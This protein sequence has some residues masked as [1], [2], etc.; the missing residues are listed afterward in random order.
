MGAV[1][2]LLSPSPSMLVSTCAQAQAAQDMSAL[3]TAVAQPC[4]SIVLDVPALQQNPE[5][6][7]GCESVALTNVLRALGFNLEKTEI[8]D[9]W[10]PVSDDDFVTAFMGDPRTPDGHSCM[11]PAIVQTAN[12]YLAAQGSELRAADLTGASFETLLGEVAAGR[13][14]IAWCT[15][16]LADPGDPY[17]IERA[18][19]RT[20]RLHANSHCVVV[21]GYDLDAETVLVSDSLVGQTSCNLQLFAERYYELGAQ[22]VI[23]A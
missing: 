8:A 16:D 11:A 10:L 1:S 5:L 6:P 17:R 9:D 4:R 20:Y 23:I 13:P 2:L 3:R 18:N 7:T 12:A 21:S 19:G 22:A 15:I 14:V